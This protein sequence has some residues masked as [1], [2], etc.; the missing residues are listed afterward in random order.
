MKNYL[1]NSIDCCN[2]IRDSIAKPNAYSFWF[3]YAKPYFDSIGIGTYVIKSNKNDIVMIFP[4]GGIV[5]IPKGCDYNN[6]L[7]R[8]KVSDDA[9]CFIY[10]NV[11]KTPY[12]GFLYKREKD[13]SI[14]FILNIE[15][16]YNHVNLNHINT[17]IAIQSVLKG[18]TPKC[19]DGLSV[20]T[21]I[22][23]F[24][25]FFHK[26]LSTDNCVSFKGG[27]TDY[28]HRAFGNVK[29]VVD[30][31]GSRCLKA[32]AFVVGE[33]PL[34][35]QHIKDWILMRVPIRDKHLVTIF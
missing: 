22:G 18:L 8:L 21:C 32:G 14:T 26:Y 16:K 10:A 33:L 13:S 23:P 3:K 24:I 27:Y 29:V 1:S 31:K 12:D 5:R 7:K 34:D 25:N 11:H 9:I 15:R 4:N 6:S 2:I 17:Y 28:L 35:A 19:L 20:H 30:S